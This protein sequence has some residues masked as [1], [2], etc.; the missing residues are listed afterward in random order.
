[1][2]RKLWLNENNNTDLVSSYNE[3]ICTLFDDYGFD[4]FIDH[5][6]SESGISSD[7]ILELSK[8]RNRLN[9]YVEKET[10]REI[11]D[12]PEWQNISEQ[13]KVIISKWH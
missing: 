1:M 2:Q 4:R 11:L 5:L 12:D 6:A 3:V 10:D 13:A 7:I 9:S 8:L